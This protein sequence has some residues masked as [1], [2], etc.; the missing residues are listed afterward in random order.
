MHTDFI[1]TVRLDAE[2]KLRLMTLKK[3]TGIANWNTLC[4]WAFC[5][6]LADETLVRERN[7]RDVGAVEMSWRTFAGDEE[8]IYRFL[9]VDRCQKDHGKTDK[10]LLSSTLRQHISRGAAR[11]AAAGGI[12]SAAELIELTH[13]PRRKVA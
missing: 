5:L 2:T 3:R 7:E 11:L 6:S 4:R 9:L 1:E 12:K 10:E 13:R 8:V